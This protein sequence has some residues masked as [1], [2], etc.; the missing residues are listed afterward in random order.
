MKVKKYA[1]IG[2]SCAGKTTTVYNV[3]GRMRKKGYHIEGLASTDR[4]YPF[5]KPKLDY[6]NEAQA[7]VVL[8]QAHLET[9][10]EVRDDLEIMVTDRST[11]DF[12]AYQEYFTKNETDPYYNAMKHFAFDWAKTYDS[13]FYVEPLP[14][15][16]DNKRPADDIRLAVDAV[17]K[18]YLPRI[19][20][21]IHVPNEVDREDFIIQHISEAQS[22][23]LPF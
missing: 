16:N 6:M 10:M 5:E 17:I 20:N 2:T 12:F 21:L 13:I 14:W 4:I 8:Q 23:E 11:V 15:V 18:S 3:V 22:L 9:R 19:P 7:Y 1:I